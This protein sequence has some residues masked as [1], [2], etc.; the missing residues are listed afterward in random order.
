MLTA[1]AFV[2]TC[3]RL[4]TYAQQCKVFAAACRRCRQGKPAQACVK[5]SHL[6]TLM[7]R[8][9]AIQ[10]IS[11]ACGF[12]SIIPRAWVDVVNAV[13]PGIGYHVRRAD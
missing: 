3:P 9:L 7:Q 11:A 12:E 13:L 10:R 1:L 4:L 6:T 8:H 5:D 2:P